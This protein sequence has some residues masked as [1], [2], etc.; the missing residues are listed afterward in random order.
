LTY[1]I[2]AWISIARIY[3]FLTTLRNGKVIKNEKLDI[4]FNSINV[5]QIMHQKA[6]LYEFF[7]KKIADAAF[8]ILDKTEGEY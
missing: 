8:L 3:A 5:R 4:V 6:K 1:G 2:T 7:A